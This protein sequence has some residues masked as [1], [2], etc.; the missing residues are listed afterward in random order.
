MRFNGRTFDVWTT[1]N[2][3]SAIPSSRRTSAGP[4]VGFVGMKKFGITSTAFSR[5]NVASVSC[6][7]LSETVV[8]DGTTGFLRPFGDT[9]ALAASLDK[10]ADSP[11]L[12]RA[13]GENGRAHAE[14]HFSAGEIVPRYEALYR[15][16]VD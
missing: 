16:L 10:L 3:S 12:T 11:E 1:R 7:K 9:D 4:R 15:R 14:A 8:I 13:L 5:S 2:S 6:R